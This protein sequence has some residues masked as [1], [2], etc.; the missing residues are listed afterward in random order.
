MMTDF[1]IKQNP[2]SKPMMAHL[3][4]LFSFLK[5]TLA[6]AFPSAHPIQKIT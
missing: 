1:K 2:K 6:K 5:K 3:F 4:L